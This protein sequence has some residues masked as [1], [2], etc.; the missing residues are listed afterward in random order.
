MISKL[1]AYRKHF[2]HILG[3]D[4]DSFN[5]QTCTV[6]QLQFV[7]DS[8]KQAVADEVEGEMAPHL[9]EEAIVAAENNAVNIGLTAS[10]PTVQKLVY[11]RGFAQAAIN[12]PAIATDLRIISIEMMGFLPTNPY[13]RLGMNL[14]RV[15]YG[16]VLAN[17]QDEM[18][19]QRAADPSFKEL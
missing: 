8:C 17:R 10:D 18:L 7:L 6:E 12:D 2:A 1:R 19:N 11:L 15:G 3:A 4:L 9:L 16:V 5:P 14:L 13:V